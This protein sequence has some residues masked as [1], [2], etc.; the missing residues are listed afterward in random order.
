MFNG[1]QEE[2]QL[3]EVELGKVVFEFP[4]SNFCNCVEFVYLQVF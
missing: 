1:D 4:L 3:G 2:T